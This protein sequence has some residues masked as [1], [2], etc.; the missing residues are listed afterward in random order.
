MPTVSS[1]ELCVRKYKAS[2]C[3][4]T[5][6]SVGGALCD[7]EGR[8]SR[9]F[10]ISNSL[11]IR[12]LR[13]RF[14]HAARYAWIGHGRNGLVDTFH[15]DLMKPIVAKVKPVAKHSFGLQLQI[16]E[17]RRTGVAMAFLL[18]PT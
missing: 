16:V 1:R 13:R 17:L 7:K 8:L 6:W 9:L 15:L 11:G 10:A 18:V 14:S 3:A 5:R 4:N 12:V 2:V